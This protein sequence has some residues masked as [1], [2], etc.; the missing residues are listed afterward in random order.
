MIS[1]VGLLNYKGQD[2]AMEGGTEDTL[3]QGL[4]HELMG[5]QYG[6]KPDPH[7]WI[8][9]LDELLSQPV[10]EASAR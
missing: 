9:P 1:P 7:G 6:Q 4:F 8:V 5:M 3:A 10:S 2:Y